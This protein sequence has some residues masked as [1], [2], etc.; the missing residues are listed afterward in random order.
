MEDGELQSIV[1][2]ELQDAINF[3]D[4]E[5]GV[6]RALALDYYKG[7]P[8]GDEEEGRSQ[9]VSRDVHDTINA[10][11]PSLMRI[12]FGPE[13][14]VEFAPVGP[15]DIKQAE[16]ATDYVN[17]V[18]TNDNDGFLVF[19]SAIKDALRSKVG[20]I[21]YWWDESVSVSTRTYSGLDEMALTGL[22]EDLQKAQEAEVV[23]SQEDEN[24]LSVVIRLKTRAD[25][26]RI[27]AVPPEEL[28]ISRDAVSIDSAR[29]V[30]HRST[31]TVSDLV[32]MGY[33]RDEIEAAAA[34]DELEANE[35]RLARN[36]WADDGDAS[37]DPTMRKMLYVEAY[38]YLDY[39]GDGIA[40]LR[41]ICT[42]GSGFKV[43]ANDPWDERP[44]ADL[45]CD[46]EPHTFFG[47]SLADKTMDVQRIKSVVLRAAL[48]SLAQNI[49]P[50]TVVVENDGNVEDAMNTEVGAILRAKTATGY[51]PLPAQ[52]LSGSALPYLSYMD[53]LRENRTGMSKVS[54]GLD[55]E[56]LQN[57]TAT[58]AEGQFTRSQERIELIARIMASGIRK[59][60]RGILKLLVENQR[61]QRVVKLRNQWTP[62]DPRSWRVNMDVVCTVGLGGGTEAEKARLL[63]LVAEKQELIMN[64]AGFVN[65]LVSPKQYHNTLSKLLELGGFRNPDAYFTDPE[66]PEGQSNDPGEP[67]PDP[68]MVEA[69]MKMQLAE[70]EAAAKLKLDERRMEAEAQAAERKAEREFELR[71]MEL[72]ANNALKREQIN[73]E[74]ML[75]REQLAAE[76]EL[77]RE[78]GLEQARVAAETGMA[79]VQASAATSE[80]NPGGEPG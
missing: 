45:H 28:L 3:I 6:E 35:E 33:D 79:R 52:D 55:A 69:Q 76:I 12:F 29:L 78:L 41:R 64:T 59:L 18:V 7:Q 49:F 62:V 10:A 4:S 34:G 32:A 30:A 61:A 73:A 2:A 9:V 21:K 75:K 37:Q 5:I 44:I 15:E 42:V 11:L 27:A 80:V 65:P 16:Q 13:N 74:L 70:Q 1:R 19:Y 77:K 25:R 54:Q 63:A 22:L 51:V 43:V 57:T 14:V 67:P 23:S 46:P 58:A 60:F 38:Q 72:E 50:R 47:Q 71:R 24:G 8:F 31:K 39:D 48:D 26:C 56:A 17:Y 53:E 20:F 36:P 68:K 66:S 40:E